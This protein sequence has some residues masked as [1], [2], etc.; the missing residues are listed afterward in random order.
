MLIPLEIL[1]AY[2]DKKKFGWSS[3][4][5]SKQAI[6]VIHHKHLLAMLSEYDSVEEKLLKLFKEIQI[7]LKYLLKRYKIHLQDLIRDFP[8]GLSQTRII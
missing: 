8:Q 1:R 4:N 3:F 6:N 2:I 5:R 7:L